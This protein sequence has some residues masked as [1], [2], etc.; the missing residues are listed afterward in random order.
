MAAEKIIQQIQ[1][2][3]QK[4]AKKLVDE[5]K[6]EAKT[7]IDNAKA[8]A[9]LEA[10]KIIAD[11]KT[12]SE[13]LKKIMIS[14]AN[15]DAKRQEMNAREKIMDECFVKAHHG[16]S[17]LKEEEYKKI[18]TKLIQQ[19]SKKLGKSC[20]V[21]VSRDYDKQIAKNL[22][23]KIDGTVEASGGVIVK[24]CDGRIILDNTFDGILK[25]EKDKIRIKVGKLLFS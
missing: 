11:G 3:A 4:E 13:N 1:K 16:L 10:K 19:G 17:T 8:S 9:E 6:K 25:R 18:V 24:S 7:I 12:K 20:S 2:D 14:Q 21:L 15:Q 5:S 22:G 23:L